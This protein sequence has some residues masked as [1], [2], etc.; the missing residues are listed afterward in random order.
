MGC[1]ILLLFFTNFWMPLQLF[2]P[3]TQ[4]YKEDLSQQAPEH[5][6]VSEKMDRKRKIL[7]RGC[8]MIGTLYEMTQNGTS[9]ERLLA[10]HSRI[11]DLDIPLSQVFKKM[12]PESGIQISDS[13]N[14][15]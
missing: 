7:E 5:E 10:L 12:I 15:Q 14:S 2:D 4:L 11:H 8:S 9:Y 6:T 13:C 3:S 1:A